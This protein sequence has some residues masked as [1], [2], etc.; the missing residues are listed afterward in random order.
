MWNFVRQTGWQVSSAPKHDEFFSSDNRS[1]A[2]SLMREMTQNSG[3]NPAAPDGPVEVRFR[4]VTVRPSA[5]PKEFFADLVPHLKETIPDAASLVQAKELTVLVVEDFGTTGLTGAFDDP[6]DN[7]NFN[8]FWRRY[9]ESQKGHSKGGRH[10][11][12]KSTAASASQIRTVFGLTT[13]VDDDKTLLY[14][15]ASLAPHVLPDE[16]RRCDSYGLYA[17]D[18]KGEPVPYQGRETDAFAKAFSLERGAR[19]G[20][21]LVIPAPVAELT[22][23]ALLEAAV[24]NCFHQ[25]LSGKLRIVVGAKTLSRESIDG[26]VAQLPGVAR[27]TEAIKFAGECVHI[28]KPV[29]EA[30]ASRDRFGQEELKPDELAELRRR[31]L[32]G[33]TVSVCVHVPVPAKVKYSRDAT[34]GQAW[35][36]LRRATSAA[37]ARETYVRGRII[38]PERRLMQT[39]DALGLL[40]VPDGPLSQF[41]GDSE[42]PSHT[43]W[44]LAK[45][46]AY[47][48]PADAFKRVRHALEDFERVVIGA[49]EEEAVKDALKHF[50]F[51]PKERVTADVFDDLRV[52]KE[53]LVIPP[54]APAVLDVR[55][56][57]GGFIAA[58]PADSAAVSRVRLEVRYN[59]RRGKP[60][61]D[62]ADFNLD[63][64]EI[65]I[66]CD[67]PPASIQRRARDGMLIIDGVEPGFRM[68][69]TGFDR[70]RDLYV[71]AQAEE[72]EHGA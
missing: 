22:E 1:I 19:T 54:A 6:L 60:K 40:V 9:G 48:A 68:K 3:D 15:Q 24:E 39:K 35:L 4:F 44:I 55:P 27:L 10:G 25:V 64:P 2:H 38:V 51:R 14:G 59:V 41:L 53:R 12:G 63:S 28:G 8:S 42:Q 20:L 26:L 50:F 31:W 56:A 49:S 7:G 61:F 16:T 72:I 30:K 32:A 69:V 66:D 46:T 34:D 11:V 29:I 23:Q 62:T 5:L 71:K 70:N 58:R 57:R 17:K 43:R 18:V 21:S 65:V 67:G 13:R 33:D 45:L 52:D 37:L 47:S 36:Y